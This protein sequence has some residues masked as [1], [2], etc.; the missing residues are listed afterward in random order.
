MKK[1]SIWK[2][3]KKADL[4]LL[5]VF[6]LAGILMIALPLLGAAKEDPQT[7]DTGTGTG[8]MVV[9]YT[10]GTEYGRY[11]LNEDKTITVSQLGDTIADTKTNI[12]EIKDGR[13]CMEKASCKNQV[14]VDTGWI[15]KKNEII[16]CLPN[17]VYVTIEDDSA[18]D[19]DTEMDAVAR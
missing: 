10:D 11:P 14:C 7:A 19:G 16:V 15:S 12:V 9:I 6:V 18:S 4:V 2:Y 13:V 8:P 5:A 1:S 17:K 3:I